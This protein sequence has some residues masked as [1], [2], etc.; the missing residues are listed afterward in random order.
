MKVKI[1]QYKHNGLHIRQLGEEQTHTKFQKIF[2]FLGTF[3][4]IYRRKG[5]TSFFTHEFWEF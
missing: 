2:L 3:I 1:N 4:A 5:I